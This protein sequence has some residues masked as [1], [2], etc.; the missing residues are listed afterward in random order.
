MLFENSIEF[1][2]ELDQLD[3]LRS[4]RDLFHI[5]KKDGKELAYFCGNSLG[6]Q[7]KS[8]RAYIETE[9]KSWE[10]H[11]VEGHFEGKHPWM[12]YHKMFAE[13]LAKIVGALPHEVVVMNNL[14]V[15][16]HLMMVSFYKPTP[17]RFKIIIE[18]GAFPSDQYA[19]ESQVK[20]HGFNPDEAIIE[21]IPRAGE[22]CLQTD[23]I[24]QCIRDN[25]E[26][27][28]LVM[29]GGVNYY[30]G[31]VFNMKE[32]SEA[33]HDAGAL[34][35]FDLAHAAGNVDLAL[36][37]WNTDFAVW[38]SYK[39]LNSGPGGSSG[40]FVHER[41]ANDSTLPR[42]AGWWGYEEATR[43]KMQKGFKPMYG[44]AGW[45]LSNAQILPMAA[46]KASLDIFEKVG[47]EALVAKTKMLSSY[48]IFL[49]EDNFKKTDQTELVII[50]PLDSHQRG[51][52]ISLLTGEN[53]K[54]L[55]N[56][57]NS[58]GI[59][60]DW[61]EPNVIRVAPVPLYNTFTD[62]YRFA[63]TICSEL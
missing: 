30:T 43:F 11:A 44:A 23:D 26:S 41:W 7:P 4:Y 39:Y 63:N 9:L 52:Q 59:I 34:V 5:P 6:L 15:N 28:A 37:D 20:F 31:Q 29:L 61:R 35:G 36:H 58:Q 57:L 40:V 53:G 60:T 56:K 18:G 21:L 55:Y 24:L 46:H 19:V 47:M 12:Y 14:S 22:Y 38:C 45:Q 13:P 8:T 49:L 51:A 3:A 27:L 62:V 2:N 48:L 32:I 54:N 25:K 1:A 50:T 33:A 10:E 17:T 42:F 16:L